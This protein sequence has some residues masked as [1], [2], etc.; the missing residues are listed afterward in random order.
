MSGLGQR[1]QREYGVEST[2]ELEDE[3][4]RTG[5]VPPFRKKFFS[6]Q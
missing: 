5:K 1:R 4:E 2:L 6:D 3:A